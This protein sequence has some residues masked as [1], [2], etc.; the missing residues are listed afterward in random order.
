MA[1]ADNPVVEAVFDLKLQNW[2]AQLFRRGP[3]LNEV[4]V[5]KLFPLP[6][7]LLLRSFCC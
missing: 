4:A 5:D 2:A 7:L 6:R 3:A 1:I